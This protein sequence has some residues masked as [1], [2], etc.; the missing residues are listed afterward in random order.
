M[1][2]PQAR[3]GVVEVVERYPNIAVIIVL[4][5]FNEFNHPRLRWRANIPSSSEEG[6]LLFWG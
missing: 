2:E 1:F 4:P 6:S 5:S 3:T